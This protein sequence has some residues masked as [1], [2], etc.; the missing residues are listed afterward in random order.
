MRGDSLEVEIY[1]VDDAET[2]AQAQQT[3]RQAAAAVASSAGR[4]TMRSYVR[5]NLLIVVREEPEPGQIG[6][7]IAPPQD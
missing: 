5:D 4:V 2:L 6:R 7:L 3:A 1:Q